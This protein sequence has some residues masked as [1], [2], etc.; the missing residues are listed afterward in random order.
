MNDC[1]SSPDLGSLQNYTGSQVEKTLLVYSACSALLF[2]VAT[3]PSEYTTSA[4]V[5]DVE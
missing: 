1:Y 4:G 3:I 5:G 2:S